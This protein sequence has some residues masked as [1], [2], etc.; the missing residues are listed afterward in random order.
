[1]FGNKAASKRKT[2][3]FGKPVRASYDAA[4]STSDNGNL[5]L[6]ADALSAATANDPATRKII[7]ERARYEVANNSYADGMVDTIV[8]DL[9]GPWVTIKLGTSDLARQ[10]E[11]DF[12]RWALKS[13]F[14]Q[15]LHQMIRAKK[16]DGE[17]FALLT[18]DKKLPTP[19]KL[20]VVPIECEMVES[21]F[22][23]P[24][25]NEIDGI[26]FDDNKNP[27]AYR[28][29]KHHPGDYRAYLK[30][31]A[32]EWID[33]KY[34]LHFFA[35]NRPG[36][37]RGVSELT[38]SLALFGQLRG[39]TVSVLEAASR[40]A[41]IAGVLE[42]DLVPDSEDGQCAADV[43]P[44]SIIPAGRNKIVSVPEGWKMNQFKA[45][46]PTTTYP[47]F[48][49]EI[50]G[51]M[52]RC[53]NLPLNIAACDSSGYNYASGRLDHQTYDRNNETERFFIGTELL[54]R[55]WSAYLQEYAAVNRLSPKQIE[56]IDIAEWFFTSRDHV[57]PGKEADADDTRIRNGTLTYSAYYAKKGLDGAQETAQWMKEQID[58][59]VTWKKL[60]K[61]N[62]LPDD[63]P[64]PFEKAAT[65]QPE[66]TNVN[67]NKDDT[68]QQ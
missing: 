33:A 21:Y 49:R 51:E 25:E 47:M 17:T 48:K 59:I 4:R 16:V 2:V 9:I 56:E 64:L 3:D 37:V 6:Y 52:G 54:D 26:R 31:K 34:V 63:T 19:V 29:L 8:S 43:E 57:D 67:K 5:W 61:E 10:D 42:T 68:T 35:A 23:Q 41:E 58:R 20:N 38:P 55:V 27:I 44:G 65:T 60:L 14:W 39:Y 30:S 53:V 32:G 24:D 15:K 1:M 45:E 50:I 46:Q 18:T 62:G 28:V 22:L 13:K 66:K 40:A 12:Q 36:Q 11:K 7:R